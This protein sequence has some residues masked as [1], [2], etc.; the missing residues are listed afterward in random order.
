MVIMKG[1][2]SAIATLFLLLIASCG[3]SAPVPDAGTVELTITVTNPSQDEAQEVEVKADLPPEL[4]QSDII[5]ADGLELKLDPGSNVYLVEGKVSLQPS[6]TT[7]YNIKVR[8][9]WSIPA[10]EIKKLKDEASGY[11]GV[12]TADMAKKLDDMLAK[13]DEMAADARIALYRKEKRQL[14]E[15]RAQ[16]ASVGSVSKA[17]KSKDRMVFL[18]AILGL[19]AAAVIITAL[20][21][22]NAAPAFQDRI[23]RIFF[24][25]HRR[26]IRLSNAIQANCR[27]LD[28]NETTPISPTKDVSNGGIAILLEKPFKPQSL[29]ELQI[30]L[31]DHDRLL[32]FDG[33][34]V[35]SKK[36]TGPEKKE[37]Y[38]TGVSF[39]EAAREDNQVLKDYIAS[40]IKR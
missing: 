32:T 20:L 25:E 7:F 38:L 13:H 19:A 26:F 21:N 29:V 39:A 40:H 6:E 31:P 23:K 1:K 10:E 18:F 22:K 27:L 3:L 11:P 30:K 14:E 2:A 36:V 24:H 4:K 9:V 15:I 17:G 5:S 37:R 12:Y 16:L 34:V 33:F 8:D 35:W 28:D